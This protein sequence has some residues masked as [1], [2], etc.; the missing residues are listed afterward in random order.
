MSQYTKSQ[1]E[2]IKKYREKNNYIEIRCRV[3]KDRR[4]KVKSHAESTDGSLNKFINRAID[5]TIQR[6]KEK[7]DNRNQS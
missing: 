3:S 2:A 6:D 5:E 4:D 7:Q 1:A